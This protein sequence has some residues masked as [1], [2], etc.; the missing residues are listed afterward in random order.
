[1]VQDC[2]VCIVF[3]AYACI[4]MH[5]KFIK[6]TLEN[7]VK[8]K[9]STVISKPYQ[10]ICLNF[11]FIRGYA[12]VNNST[13]NRAVNWP[14]FFAQSCNIWTLVHDVNRD[15]FAPLVEVL[16]Q[17]VAPESTHWLCHFIFSK[18]ETY[19]WS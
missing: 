4:S 9:N 5:K 17:S 2:R 11:L 8:L 6:L 12:D 3:L 7:Y 10:N 16:L 18:P 15:K 1:M 19:P 13:H 14:G